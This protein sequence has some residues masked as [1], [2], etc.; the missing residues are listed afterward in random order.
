[1]TQ[2]ISTNQQLLETLNPSSLWKLF[3]QLSDIPRPSNDEEAVRQWIVNLVK[4]SNLVYKIDKIGNIA[5]YKPA[6]NSSSLTKILLQAHMDMVTEKDPDHNHNFLHD[7]LK[8]QIIGDLVTATNTT[9][10]ADNGIGLCA[11]LAVLIH[12][13]I[14]HPP[15][16]VLVTMNEEAGMVGIGKLDRTL[17]SGDMIINLD[18]EEEGNVYVSSAGGRDIYIEMFAP[19]FEIKDKPLNSYERVGDPFWYASHLENWQ[20]VEINLSGLSGGHSGADIHLER[21]NPL[22]ELANILLRLPNTNYCF[23]SIDGGNKLN[24][25]PRDATAKIAFLANRAF[26][27]DNQKPDGKINPEIYGKLQTEL[28]EFLATESA[29]LS[30][31]ESKAIITANWQGQAKSGQK[32]WSNRTLGKFLHL[33]NSLPNGVIEMSHIISD[34]VQTSSNIGRI[35]TDLDNGVINIGIMARSSD[36]YQLLKLGSQIESIVRLSSTGNPNLGDMSSYWESPTNQTFFDDFYRQNDFQA[37]VSFAGTKA[38]WKAQSS[39]TLLDKFQEVHKDLYGKE[40]KIMAIHAGLECGELSKYLPKADIIS[41]G[42]DI[43]DAHTPRENVSI[44]SVG[45][46]YRLLVELLGRL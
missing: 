46:F 41:F 33:I 30:Q 3:A 25:I 39:N 7:P 16:E 23:I 36:D 31:V 20:V 14:S 43:R 37:Q 11:A 2:V 24:A 13:H 17:I 40:A 27:M 45:E 10:G 26:S 21:I 42:P 32:M 44:R 22:Q 29:R 35:S 5:I 12:T 4:M 38:G 28:E 6:Q 34:L 18:C 8:L 19:R 9:L 1:M 15:L